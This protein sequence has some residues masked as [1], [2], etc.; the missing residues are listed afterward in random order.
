MT[1][2]CLQS[3]YS[4]VHDNRML[5]AVSYTHL[6]TEPGSAAGPGIIADIDAERLEGVG[7]DGRKDVYK[8]QGLYP[9]DRAR[10]GG[11]YR[12]I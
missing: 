4:I 1:I 3:V 5:A 10:Y 12:T 9:A 8:R 7:I 6:L 2:E 11:I